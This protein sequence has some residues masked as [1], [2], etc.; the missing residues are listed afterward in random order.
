MT[1]RL[2]SANVRDDGSIVV[3]D[4]TGIRQS[5]GNDQSVSQAVKSYKEEYGPLD[6]DPGTAADRLSQN[7]SLVLVQRSKDDSVCIVCAMT[8]QSVAWTDDT[9]AN[10]LR[11]LAFWHPDDWADISNGINIKLATSP[12]LN[13][14]TV[15]PHL[16]G[17][18]S[19][20]NRV[21]HGMLMK[22]M[23]QALGFPPKVYPRQ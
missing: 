23:L 2:M 16:V 11:E 10:E 7:E 6:L 20:P 5:L 17:L 12:S 13:A 1:V 9:S 14:V 4:H 19:G 22:A 21:H 18:R 3:L 8:R 15:I